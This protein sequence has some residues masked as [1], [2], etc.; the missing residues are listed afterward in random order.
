MLNHRPKT[1]IAGQAVQRIGCAVGLMLALSACGY[2][3]PLYMPPPP[4]APDAELTTPPAAQQ[5][6]PESVT[7]PATLPVSRQ[8]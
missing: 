2:K 1:P 4:P 5:G 3:G 8:D 6:A 7:S